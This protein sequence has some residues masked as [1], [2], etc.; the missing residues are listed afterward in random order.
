MQVHMN[1]P[2]HSIPSQGNSRLTSPIANDINNLDY[3][4][5]TVGSRM[6]SRIG[7]ERLAII[8]FT[9]CLIKSDKMVN[10]R[11]V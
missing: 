4:G 7:K 2:V 5:S 10:G 9:G 1:Y 3:H 8:K 11:I 6:G